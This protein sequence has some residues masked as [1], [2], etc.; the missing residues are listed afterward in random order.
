MRCPDFPPVSMVIPVRDE[1]ATLEALLASIRVQTIQPD[2]TIFVDGGSTDSTVAMLRAAATQ[3]GR[4]RV[5]EA[6]EASPGRGRNV[7]IS[8]ASFDWIALTDAGIRLDPG[9][10]QELLE[11]HIR[12]PEAGIIFGNYAPI[13]ESFFESCA[14]IAY[15]PPPHTSSCGRMR[16][17]CIASCLLN[18]ELWEQVGGFPDLR[19]AEDLIF[20]ERLYQRNS[21]MAWAPRALVWWRLRPTLTE[22]YRRFK[23][24]SK[25]NVW[26]RRERDWHYGI[27]RQYTAGA[28]LAMLAVLHTGWWAVLL[29]CGIA[30]RIGRA[31]WRNRQGYSRSSLLNPARFVLV[32]VILAVIDVATF[33]GWV[34]AKRRPDLAPGRRVIPDHLNDLS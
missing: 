23:L 1:I 4:I 25:H 10:L 33:V 13:T 32:G 20:I 19:A 28:V 29:G 12:A 16:G 2:E 26:G 5:I 30:A 31:L 6:G 24:Y 21:R 8:A 34:H 15:V 7:G 14:A 27:A 18:R 22:T 17:P 3:D 11:A 9:W